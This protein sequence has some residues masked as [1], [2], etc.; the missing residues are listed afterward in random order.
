M[1]MLILHWEWL[2]VQRA[3]LTCACALRPGMYR[4]RNQ[5]PEFRIQ[6]H[7]LQH[8]YHNVIHAL[9]V[10]ELEIGPRLRELGDSVAFVVVT[11]LVEDFL[12]GEANGCAVELGAQAGFFGDGGDVRGLLWRVNEV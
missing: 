4:Y 8:A 7:F 3:R 6:V 9:G 12:A 5:S 1:L 2:F 11:G 10:R